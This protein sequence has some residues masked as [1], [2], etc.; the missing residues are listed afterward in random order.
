MSA[1]WSLSGARVYQPA[2]EFRESPLFNR[3]VLMLPVLNSA[4][5]GRT[6]L[7]DCLRRL[8]AD[9]ARANE[10]MPPV[11]PKDLLAHLGDLNCCLMEA[12]LLTST[13]GDRFIV[14]RRG[15]ELLAE[16]PAGIDESVLVQFPEFRSFIQRSAR[17]PPA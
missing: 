7:E 17:R 9:L 11:D 13:E 2:V 3:P 14:T 15:R 4:S 10:P 6:P 16:H 12:A 5:P 1:F 8:R